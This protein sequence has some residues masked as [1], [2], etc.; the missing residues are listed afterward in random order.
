MKKSRGSG[1]CAMLISQINST[2]QRPTTTT[3]QFNSN[4]PPMERH[5]DQQTAQKSIPSIYGNAISK[6]GKEKTK[7][8]NHTTK[9][10][11][12]GGEKVSNFSSPSI[13][14]PSF[15][16]LRALQQQN[17]WETIEKT[18]HR[19]ICQLTLTDEFW[20]LSHIWD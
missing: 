5:E 10:K 20:E 9:L 19:K 15:T 1:G 12:R 16:F 6:I 2:R 8:K 17:S 13:Q 11:R 3:N 18:K 4:L 7:N 14:T